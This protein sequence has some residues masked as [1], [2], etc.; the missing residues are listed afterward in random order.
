MLR[1]IPIILSN[2]SNVGFQAP[3]KASLARPDPTPD[4]TPVPSNALP[5][6]ALGPPEPLQRKSKHKN[7]KL[8]REKLEQSPRPRLIGIRRQSQTSSSPG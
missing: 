5:D 1:V 3:L 7:D 2:Y 8:G 4:P 6:P